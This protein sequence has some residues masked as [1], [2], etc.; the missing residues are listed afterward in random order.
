MVADLNELIEEK[1][2]AS[3]TVMH[4]EDLP[5]CANSASVEL[6]VNLEPIPLSENYSTDASER[7]KAP[8]LS[9]RCLHVRRLR[10][11]QQLDVI[12]P[13]NL[14]DSYT[15]YSGEAKGMPEHFQQV[16]AKIIKSC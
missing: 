13:K 4:H 6:V 8:A 14:W 9:G 15:Y 2:D 5:T 12:D 7:R 16:A 3:V 1:T 10:H 11:V